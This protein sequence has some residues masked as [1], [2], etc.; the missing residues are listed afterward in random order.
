MRERELLLFGYSVIAGAAFVIGSYVGE[1]ASL[2]G[3]HADIAPAAVQV[4]VSGDLPA[5]GEM[6][7]M[8]AD[9]EVTSFEPGDAGSDG[10][11]PQDSEI[12]ATIDPA[13]AALEEADRAGSGDDQEQHSGTG[14]DNSK[15]GNSQWDNTTWDNGQ[16]ESEN[17]S[18]DQPSDSDNSAEAIGE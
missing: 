5:G 15:W 2:P 3:A 14:W 11:V 7:A 4:D 12:D 16:G 13:A 1:I 6:A 8:E 18:N 9:E 17:T 10:T